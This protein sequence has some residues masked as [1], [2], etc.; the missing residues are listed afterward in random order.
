[1]PVVIPESFR[2]DLDQNVPPFPFPVEQRTRQG[3]A[4]IL[5][6]PILPSARHPDRFAA[7]RKEVARCDHSQVGISGDLLRPRSSPFGEIAFDQGLETPT[8]L[9]RLLTA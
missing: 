9:P 6:P 5:F 3:Q 7:H 8:E 4:A 2:Q 1:M